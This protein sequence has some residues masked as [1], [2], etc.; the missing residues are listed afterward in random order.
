MNNKEYK[1]YYNNL[2][3]NKQELKNIKNYNNPT[4][5]NLNLELIKYRMKLN[6][7]KGSKNFKSDQKDYSE[8]RIIKTPRI[9]QSNPK[10]FL[11]NFY[12]NY[13]L[14]NNIKNIFEKFNVNN[15]EM[16]KNQSDNNLLS[17]LSNIN[18]EKITLDNK[19]NSNKFLT[20]CSSLK[21]IKEKN[22]N[23]IENN[24]Y[25]YKLMQNDKEKINFNNNL[26]VN[27]QRNKNFDL[28]IHNS[29]SSNKL[30][31]FDYTYNNIN[32]NNSIHE[33]INKKNKENLNYMEYII[34]Q[35]KK[36]THSQFIP[37][38]N[39]LDGKINKEIPIV[40]PF[41]FT[42]SKK[43]NSNSECKRYE[44]NTKALM[45]LVYFLKNNPDKK[46][47]LI[48]E[49]FIK[50]KFPIELY[51]EDKIEN[52]YNFI[53]YNFEKIDFTKIMKDI[54]TDGIN[55]NYNEKLDY[56]NKNN[57]FKDLNPNY[58]FK[59]NDNFSTMYR[60]FMNK[61]YKDY[62]NNKDNIFF[63]HE[64]GKIDF[65]EKK[66]NICNSLNKQNEINTKIN[67]ID[68]NN[69]NNNNN[70]TSLNFYKNLKINK[71]E[72]EIH[73]INEIHI[74]KN[75]IDIR[76][77]RLYYQQKIKKENENPEELLKKNKKLLEYI[78]LKKAKSKLELEKDLLDSYNS[79]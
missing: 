27:T 56:N 25:Y 26:L 1:F 65:F 22:E 52:F 39:F 35:N 55:F 67:K 33:I 62:K 44:K 14:K 61:K 75:N 77:K 57:E 38:S 50:Y 9:K 73:K 17:K 41:L 7:L 51:N 49:F 69:N 18:K 4:N 59:I 53:I 76:N 12:N 66:N 34:N 78:V 47:E 45:R 30:S 5:K 46:F 43:F 11:N 68:V 54:I 10:F 72:N 36:N 20:H 19:K 13:N 48:N 42:F 15:K 63:N 32:N 71:L 37:S 70:N 74:G 60:T 21:E 23:E 8:F 3:S 28:T 29:K 64:L 2:L 6:Y 16:I 24:N 40:I 58:H 31:S 79:N